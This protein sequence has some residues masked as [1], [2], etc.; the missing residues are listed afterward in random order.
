MELT[1]ASRWVSR[2]LRR[3]CRPCFAGGGSS[4]LSL[5]ETTKLM[6]SIVTAVTVVSFLAMLGC[7][8]SVK[9]GPAVILWSES[10]N[11]LSLG[12]EQPRSPFVFIP[13]K[14]WKGPVMVAARDGGPPIIN[15]GGHWSE[16]AVVRVFIRN[17]S[18]HV[19]WWSAEHGANAGEW[20]VR[21]CKPGVPQPS[22]FFFPMPAPLRYWTTKQYRVQS[23]LQR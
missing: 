20:K 2:V 6:K 11:G 22:T 3:V 13:V 12:I 15:A 18:D 7:T 5:A 21:V 8:T 16:A 1:A 4:Y 14:G 23:S 10:Q 17:A 9:K 19:I